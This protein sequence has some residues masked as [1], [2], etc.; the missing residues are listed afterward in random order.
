MTI[1]WDW[2]GTLIADVP[3]V[4]R[5]N[6][7][8]FAAHGYPDT[9]EE[10]Y[11]RLFCFPVRNYYRALGVT[12]EDF[13]LIAPEWNRL[14]V[15]H[16]DEAALTEGAAQTV[17][18]F[19]QAGF[20][21]V[22]I[23]ASQQDQLRAQVARFPELEGMFEEILG[24]GDVYAVSKVQLAKDYLARS[25]VA[26][27]DAVFLGDTCH[28][29]EVARAIGCRCMLLSGGHQCDGVLAGAGVPVLTSLQQMADALGA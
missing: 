3:L 1:L 12:D 19:H 17:R 23:S 29:A 26:P 4:V 18:R 21:Q 15:E 6:N 16:F 11:R 22:I 24:L 13:N 14:Y 9:D 25:G 7:I 20:R 5:M 2:N 8:V 27:E 10:A 28:D